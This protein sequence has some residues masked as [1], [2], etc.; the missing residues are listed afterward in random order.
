MVKVNN[1]IIKIELFLL[2]PSSNLLGHPFVPWKHLVPHLLIVVASTE[3][4][5]LYF[6]KDVCYWLMMSCHM[7]F[8]PS[9]MYLIILNIYNLHQVVQLSEVLR[10]PLLFFVLVADSCLRRTISLCVF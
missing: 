7:C 1:F 5:F 6:I 10:N 2:C 4:H 8:I 9:F 3:D